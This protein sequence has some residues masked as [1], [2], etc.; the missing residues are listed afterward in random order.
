MTLDRSTGSGVG[1]TAYLTG[2]VAAAVST[3]DGSRT[4]AAASEARCAARPLDR[5]HD[6]HEPRPTLTL[7]L[8]LIYAAAAPTQPHVFLV[9][10]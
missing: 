7:Y 3:A 5:A 2:V 9:Y 4:S 8:R 10:D 1:S 6:A